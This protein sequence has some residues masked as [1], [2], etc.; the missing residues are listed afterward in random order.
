MSQCKKN[1][2]SMIFHKQF[3]GLYLRFGSMCRSFIFFTLSSRNGFLTNFLEQNKPSGHYRTSMDLND[4][5]SDCI[6]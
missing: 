1:F 2:L 3:T 5:S 4:K 6:H